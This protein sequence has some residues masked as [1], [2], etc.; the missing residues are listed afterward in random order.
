[1]SDYGTDNERAR[2]MPWDVHLFDPGPPVIALE[3]GAVPVAEPVPVCE[4]N[5]CGGAP[6]DSEGNPFDP[7]TPGAWCATHLRMERARMRAAGVL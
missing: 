6:V 2:P 1:M 4:W 3:A 5:G 7:S